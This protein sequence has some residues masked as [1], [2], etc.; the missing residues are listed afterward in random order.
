[1]DVIR[2]PGEAPPEYE[3]VNVPSISGESSA[4]DMS[5]ITIGG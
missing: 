2:L 4:V 3:E 1:M 5:A